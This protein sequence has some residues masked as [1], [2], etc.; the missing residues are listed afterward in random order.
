MPDDG[1]ADGFAGRFPPAK[2]SIRNDL[3]GK[4]PAI[5][6]VG[7]DSANLE[8]LSGVDWDMARWSDLFPVAMVKGNPGSP[9]HV[10]VPGSYRV[11]DDVLRFEPKFPIDA[12]L[13]H[14]ARFRP[15]RL[16]VP[17]AADEIRMPL[18]RPESR[19]S[20]PRAVVRV[21]PS[22]DRVP[23]NLLKIYIQFSGPMSRGE[24]YKRVSLID[25]T[26]KKLEM[27]FLELGEE[28]WDP[29]GTRITLLLDPGRI[30][31]GLKPR[32]EDGPI[33]ES[34]KKYTLEIDENWPDASARPLKARFRK[35]YEAGPPIEARL[36]AGS[37][38][39]TPPEAGSKDP[40]SIHFPRPLDRAMLERCLVVQ[41]AD[42]RPIAGEIRIDPEATAWQFRP[43]AS[44]KPGML[45][46]H[47]D[48]L[49]EDLAG[50]SLARPFEVDIQHPVG[51][52]EARSIV[53]PFRAVSP[54]GK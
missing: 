20:E 33:L 1:P 26:G 19:P 45:A 36:D 10:Q 53:L 18:T 11:V 39:I 21:D 48:P 50:N 37:W 14:E 22:S 16:P 42:G 5:E 13:P 40:L 27:P 25:A 9:R 12:D 23:E 2:P 3:G 6:V 29:S 52:V 54:R 51:E 46:I 17:S 30:K 7:I 15:S 28:L 38:K 35:T 41:G 47:V 4:V 32:E 34:G 24:A 8:K 43:N 44:W 49:L 31:R